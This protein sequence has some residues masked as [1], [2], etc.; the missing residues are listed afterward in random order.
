M[1]ACPNGAE[2]TDLARNTQVVLDVGAIAGSL[3]TLI[4]AHNPTAYAAFAA[5]LVDINGLCA[6][7]PDPPKA[8]T[9]DDFVQGLSFRSGGVTLPNEL[10]NRYM[11]DWLVYDV[12][13][14]SCVCKPPV[15]NPALN[16]LHATNVTIPAG[17][18]QIV[19]LGTV[20]IEPAVYDSWIVFG[21]GDLHFATNLGATFTS[22][23]SGAIN[24]F[25]QFLGSDGQW[26]DMIR[27]DAFPVGSHVDR[28]FEISNGLVRLPRL[29][30]TRIRTN[31]GSAGVLPTLD[32]CFIPLKAVPP[33]L[34]VQ[35][36][37]PTLP[38]VP[39]PVCATED[40]CAIVQELS[41]QLTR[42]SAE[43]SDILATVGGKD[44]LRELGQQTI[45]G[46]GQL[47]LVLGTRA[48]SVELT[49]L[50]P[51]VYTSALG[52]PRGLMRAGSIRWGDGV[53]YSLREFIDAE[54]FTRLRPQGAL[55]ISWQLINGCAGVLRFLG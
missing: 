7:N 49:T 41:R 8:L 35:D 44:Q 2:P 17:N 26:V 55:T 46:E 32:L 45:F 23:A 4:R 15:V 5:S 34:P 43:V 14:V 1:G 13:L 21:N 19:P 53:G 40:L 10:L 51:G 16:C 25:V 50:G 37:L 9:I 18:N 42:V 36:P 29:L 52:R 24:W 11:Y 6:S 54:D 20:S 31:F 30:N 28:E 3:A 12:F 33:P 48:V 27:G 38:T 22:G 39:P 47:D